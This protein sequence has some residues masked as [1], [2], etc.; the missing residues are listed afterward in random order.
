M[1]RP[2]RDRTGDVYG[3]LTVLSFSHREG[4]R[5][6]YVYY[7][8]CQCTCGREV[9]MAINRL[10]NGTAKSCGCSRRGADADTV[11]KTY[12]RLNVVSF[13][14]CK[15]QASYWNTLCSCGNTIIVKR[16]CL[17]ANNVRSC[18]CWRVN[19]DREEAMYKRVFADMKGLAKQRGRLSSI[20]FEHFMSIVTQPC[21]YC[22]VGTSLSKSDKL[23]DT[24][25]HYNGID[26]VDSLKGYIDGNCVPCCHKCNMVKSNGTVDEFREYALRLS[27][28][29]FVKGKGTDKWVDD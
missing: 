3:R 27:E 15:N 1:P 18:G 26:R 25:V 13:A 20:S 12:G 24:V 2:M 14:Y 29:D 16:A 6:S 28:S 11:G 21:K 9:R 5:L 22:G 23:T 7:W 4:T 8:N 17:V 19:P 10:R